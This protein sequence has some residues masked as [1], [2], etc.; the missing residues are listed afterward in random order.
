MKWTIIGLER[1]S[2]R[3][4]NKK[5]NITQ[6]DLPAII[7][8]QLEVDGDDVFIIL[9]ESSRIKTNTPCAPWKRST[10][11][12][13]IS[14]LNTT[15]E[16]CA[17]TGTL[18][19]KSAVNAYDQYNFLKKGYF[20]E[21]MFS[22]AEDYCVM[23]NLPVGRGRRVLISSK[24][25]KQVHN[26][27]A[28]VYKREGKE[29]LKK[30][31]ESINRRLGI[32]T[33]GCIWIM[34]NQEYTPFMNI[35]ELRR[36]MAPI[37]M[38]IK[39]SDVFDVE[40]EHFVKNPI[41]RTVKISKAAKKIGKQLVDLGFSENLTLHGG[42]SLELYHRLQDLCNGI[43]PI[44]EDEDDPVEYRPLKE[45]PKMDMIEELLEEIGIE[46]NQVVIFS[47]RSNFTEL[48]KEKMEEL[49]ITYCCYTGK[50]SDE[51]KVLS[52]KNFQNGSARVM[53]ANP[54]SAGYGLNS[55]KGCNYAIYSCVDAS[56]ERFF[57][58]KHRLLRG[59]VQEMKFAYLVYVENS[60][61]EKIYTALDIGEE[62]L[63]GEVTRDVFDFD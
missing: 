38:T 63:E 33:K 58:S 25:W 29:A 26:Y 49:D 1:F 56:V 41:K 57:Q 45:N 62:L 4:L 34:K 39:R 16:R 52:E 59:Q 60:V 61:E 36:R 23:M 9:D 3:G 47:A 14:T 18:M 43:E 28:G 51:E 46:E 35:D 53:I 48:L 50:E 10:R 30:A 37:T 17:L 31:M 55:L 54:A 20:K 22:F 27:F 32:S 24:T 13:L 2:P 7:R 12:R 44:R 8:K 40:N 15:G 42:Q 21:S 6:E 5:R 19:S 11:T